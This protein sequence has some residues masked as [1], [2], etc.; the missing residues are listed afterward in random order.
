MFVEGSNP[1]LLHAYPA[2]GRQ[3]WKTVLVACM[4]SK[5]IKAAAIVYITGSSSPKSSRLLPNPKK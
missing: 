2:A 4:F 1:S 5:N 3:E